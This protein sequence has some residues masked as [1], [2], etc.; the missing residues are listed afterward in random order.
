MHLLD[1]FDTWFNGIAMENG[2]LERMHWAKF[3]SG[4]PLVFMKKKSLAI[5]SDKKTNKV[6]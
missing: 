6:I 2:G 1:L 3:L 4:F 5:N